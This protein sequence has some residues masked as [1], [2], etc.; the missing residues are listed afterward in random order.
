MKPRKLQHPF[1][2]LQR[3]F[4]FKLIPAKIIVLMRCI[5]TQEMLN[6]RVRWRYSFNGIMLKMDATVCRDLA[7]LLEPNWEATEPQISNPHTSNPDVAS[8][9]APGL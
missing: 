1:Q 9:S 4:G 2:Q 7:V 8:Q 3:I 5:P 6:D